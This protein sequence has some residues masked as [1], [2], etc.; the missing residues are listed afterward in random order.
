MTVIWV[1][2][3]GI[4]INGATALLFMSGRKSDLNIQG[5][6]LHMAADAVVSL[7]VVIAALA[8]MSTGWLWLDP[9][10]SLASLS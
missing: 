7:G 5:A 2:T 1:A 6:F 10:V 4:A 8:D 3:I 9:A